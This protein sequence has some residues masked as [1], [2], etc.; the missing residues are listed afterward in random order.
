MK[1]PRSLAQAILPW[2]DIHFGTGLPN[3]RFTNGRTVVDIIGML[4]H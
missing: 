3:V 1:L 4:C 2:Y